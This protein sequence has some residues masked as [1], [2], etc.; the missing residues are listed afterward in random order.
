M[1][2][3]PP[4]LLY[5]DMLPDA[6]GGTWKLGIFQLGF[7]VYAYSK[8]LSRCPSNLVEIQI[9]RLY[10]YS[11]L[12]PKMTFS[13]WSPRHWGKHWKWRCL[14]WGFCQWSQIQSF[15]LYHVK[16]KKLTVLVYLCKA[17]LWKV[18][19]HV[20]HVHWCWACMCNGSLWG[21][22]WA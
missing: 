6:A 19:V 11:L 17:A 15:S 12:R 5:R 7:R 21:R 16:R 14:S 4:P 9:W 1:P 18:H 22:N 13:H 2:P 8:N 10:L 3:P 20:S